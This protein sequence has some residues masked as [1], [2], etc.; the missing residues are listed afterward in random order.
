M[1]F[2][3][4]A[5]CANNGFFSAQRALKVD[6]VLAVIRSAIA[7]LESSVMLCQ[8]HAYAP[9]DEP[10]VVVIDVSKYHLNKRRLALH[11][12]VGRFDEN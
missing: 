5:V 9:M 10:A 6:M 1:F 7:Q 3:L 11:I 8:A 2:C 4:Q 12:Q